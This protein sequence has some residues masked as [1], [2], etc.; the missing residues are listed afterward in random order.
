MTTEP[1]KTVPAVLARFDTGF[2]DFARAFHNGE[3]VLW[4]GS[5]IS[6]DKVPD[7][8]ALLER[9]LELL[10]SRID[11]SD[12][13]C[14]YRTALVEVLEIA[15]LDVLEIES[16]DYGVKVC[17]W[18]NNKQ[19]V[20]ALV[21]QYAR[22]L[23][24]LVGD[25]NPEDFLVWTGLDVPNTYGAPELDPDIEHYCI[26]ILM[27]EGLVRSA[28]TANW[29]GLLEKALCEL[30]PAFNE[31]AR[32][33]VT[34]EDFRQPARQFELIKFHGCAVR[35]RVDETSYRPLLVARQSQISGWAA[36][37][38][39]RPM[40]MHLELLYTDHPTLM[41]GLSAQDAN[42]HNVFADAIQ[43]LA[44]P[45]P[46]TPPAV[47][48]S[49]E[50][51][52]S[53][54]RLLLRLTYGPSHQGNATAIADSALLGS[55]G[56]PTLLALVLASLADKLVVLVTHALGATWDA[57]E[58]GRLQSGLLGLR[59]TAADSA[60][61]DRTAFLAR[62]IDVV[63]FALTIFRT[64]RV[65]VAGGRRYEPLSER[66]ISQVIHSPDFPGRA[67]GRLGIAIALIGRGQVLG[68][69]ST[70]PGDS[71]SPGGG[72]LHLLTDQRDARVFFVKD[73]A[74]KTALVLDLSIDE[75]DGNVLI[76]MADEEPLASTRSPRSNFGRDGKIRAG[77]FNVATS[78]RD[79]VSTDELFGAFKNAGGF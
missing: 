34:P 19:V 21:N 37:P 31:I 51:L 78:L 68:H 38:A 27:L 54:H 39:N 52:H 4:L 47:V 79:N 35:A 24:V 8:T 63:D 74:T 13:N 72:V 23:D 76:V 32:V 77:S 55:F 67:F 14:V 2:S 64:G 49:E 12:E 73:S 59:D 9:V 5:G 36:N 66:P 33:V 57:G 69:W 43:N 30:N 41:V 58:L 15:G 11:A 17:D 75:S 53:H 18:A 26:A 6:R 3:Y 61:T 10:R 45:W 65:R 7:V 50:Q 28:V 71:K 70:I 56:K 60:D 16:M 1:L 20:R 46:A 40:L 22:V 44:R 42:L 25:A 62:F 48:L 29:D